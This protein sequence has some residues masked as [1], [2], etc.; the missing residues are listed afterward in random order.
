M[1][2]EQAPIVTIT[3][4]YSAG[5]WVCSA[6]AEVSN[7]GGDPFDVVVIGAGMYGGYIADKVRRRG[8]QIGLRVQVV[9]ARAGRSAKFIDYDGKSLSRYTNYT[10]RRRAFYP[11]L[12]AKDLPLVTLGLDVVVYA[13]SRAPVRYLDGI[14]E[15][16]RET[17]ADFFLKQRVHVSSPSHSSSLVRSGLHFQDDFQ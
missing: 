8:E 1:S 12:A 9:D 11:R 15:P 5:R 7:N 16:L 2:E 4:F 13:D 3:W 10:R 17:D 6:W 14:A